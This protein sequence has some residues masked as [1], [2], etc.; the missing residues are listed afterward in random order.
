ML[1]NV[2]VRQRDIKDCGAASLLSIIKYYD[3]Y[4]PL[5]K[6]RQDAALS[7]DGITA[8]NLILAA[9]KYG[10]DATGIKAT[11]DDLLSGQILLPAIAYVTLS[12]GLNHY[13]VIYKVNKKNITIMD[14]AK[15]IKT[16]KLSDFNKI[17]QNV[18]IV[19]YPKTEIVK[20]E[21]SNKLFDLI[22]GVIAGEQKLINYLIITSILLI[23][24]SIVGSFYMKV[25]LNAVNNSLQNML[26][27]IALVF[28]IICI[29]KAITNYLKNYYSNYLN[30]NIDAK[31][32]VPFINHIFNLPLKAMNN[33]T[34]GEIMTRVNELNNIKNLFSEVII[35]GGL[36]LLLAITSMIVLYNVSST[37]SL[38]LFTVL[39]IYIL[40]N[41]LL[42]KLIERQVNK[43]IIAET[44]SNALLTSY[45]GG[46]TSI[47]NINK[48]EYFQNNME[49]YL[50]RY[51]KEN[52]NFT[53]LINCFT[54][55][56]D[57]IMEIGLFI[58]NTIG[59][60]MILKNNLELIDLI[61][62]DSLY[63][64]LIDPI[65]QIINL[66]PKYY[67]IKNSFAKINDFILLKEEDLSEVSND[68]SNG[69]IIFHNT[70][71]TYNYYQYPLQNFNLNI[72][73]GSKVLITGSSGCGK[74]TMFKLI[75]RLYEPKSGEI[76][77][78]DVNIKD[79]KL[80]NLRDNI[81]Y[82]SQDEM[83][84]TD[85]L[86]NNI[87]LGQDISVSVLNEV[88]KLCQI[89]NIINKKGFRLDSF[90]LEN[91]ANLSGGE[92]ARIILARCLLKNTPII[93]IDETF[94]QIEESD[95]NIIINRMMLKYKD[96]TILLISHFIPNYQF[97]QV[98]RMDNNE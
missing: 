87:T 79:Y 1:K 82:V 11:S 97:D 43:N 3:G 23:I 30:K 9:K 16:I 6:I 40:F 5:E 74:S 12:N 78:N 66:I 70:S 98:L 47:K 24:F 86:K 68:F 26:K 19:L 92:K 33:Y 65:K 41:L 18:L 89:D 72:K 28:A 53:K 55:I 39:I 36:N 31:I 57:F 44:N 38:A 46:F 59:L 69:D 77:I 29:L 48:L 91:G 95:A 84:F 4:V 56:N 67:L 35:S 50:I 54:F 22:I 76:L 13:V 32:I 34:T 75:Y 42:L 49:I 8:Y 81:T 25:A 73:K 45:I 27:F 60:Y 20:Y 83:I 15:G 63:L 85:S 21:K 71:F 7:K 51:L 2:D 80:K 64:Y 58:T 17:W 52:F 96:R 61:T 14:P 88:I 94:A 37:L 93:M 10:F 62:F 90:I